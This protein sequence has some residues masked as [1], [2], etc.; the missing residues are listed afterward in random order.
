MNNQ[1]IVRRID[2]LGRIII[3]KDIRRQLGWQEG[4]PVVFVIDNGTLIMKSYLKEE[5]KGE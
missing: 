2:E 5:S 1:D 4:D 3:P